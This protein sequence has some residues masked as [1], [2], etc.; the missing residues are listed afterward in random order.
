MMSLKST[1]QLSLCYYTSYC[2]YVPNIRNHFVIFVPILF[3]GYMINNLL[4]SLAHFALLANVTIILNHRKLLQEYPITSRYTQ[5]QC[6]AV[7]RRKWRYKKKINYAFTDFFI[8]NSIPNNFYLKLFFMGCVFLATLSPKY[9]VFCCFNT[10]Y[11]NH[12]NLSSPLAKLRGE[13]DICV[14]GLFYTKF[15]FQQLLSEAFFYGMC[16]FG[17]VES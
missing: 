14:P 16:I 12:I 6:V 15:N 17:G 11:L 3:P 10:Q 7:N 4:L 5:L 9:N 8:W 2:G 1:Y 13:I